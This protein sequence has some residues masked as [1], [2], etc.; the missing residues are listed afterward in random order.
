MSCNVNLLPLNGGTDGRWF[1]TSAPPGAG[2]INLACETAGPYDITVSAPSND[3]PI[4]TA[5]PDVYDIWLQLPSVEGVYIFTFVSPSS[6]DATDCGSSECGGC[7][8]FTVTVVEGIEY[9]DPEVRCNNVPGVLNLFGI[10]GVSCADWTVDYKAGSPEDNG[11]DLTSD[12][13]LGLGDFDPEAVDPDTYIFTFTK[14]GALEGCTSCE[15]E[16]ELTIDDAPFLG[17]DQED[18]LCLI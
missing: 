13:F 16:L 3:T 10:A 7:S 1:W 17:Y 15:F 6:E 5:C 14:I 18:A 2:S 12:C 9:L 8:T 4:A 11:F